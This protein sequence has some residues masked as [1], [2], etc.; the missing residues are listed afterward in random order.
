MK[1]VVERWIDVPAAAVWAALARLEHFAESD[2]FH[3]DLRWLSDRREGIGAEFTLRHTYRPIF[4]FGEDVVRCAVTEWIPERR[5]FVQETNARP[6]KSHAQRFY[7]NAEN[8]GTR[9]R[10]EIGYVGVPWAL[11]AWRLWVDWHVTARMEAKL[12][13][14]EAA[15]A[16]LRAAA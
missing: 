10:Y 14:I 1:Y 2:P 12:T 15:S 5:L 16:S 8:G 13:D 6:W 9:L 7:L 3:H 4:P 11:L